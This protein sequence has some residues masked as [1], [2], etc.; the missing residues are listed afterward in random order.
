MSENIITIRDLINALLPC[1]PNLP[2]NVYILDDDIYDT[3]W[4]E[5]IDY[6]IDDRID[7]NCYSQKQ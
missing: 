1:D 7:I 6:S 5:G 3:F 4:I 2:V